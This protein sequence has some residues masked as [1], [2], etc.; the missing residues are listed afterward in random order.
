[1]SIPVCQG[2]HTHCVF[3]PEKALSAEGVAKATFFP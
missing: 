3:F 1:M 2:S